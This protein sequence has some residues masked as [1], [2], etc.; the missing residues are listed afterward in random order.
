MLG[1]LV[2]LQLSGP[3]PADPPLVTR[4]RS[5][6]PITGSP[7][8][9]TRKEACWRHSICAHCLTCV[10]ASSVIDKFVNVSIPV[11]QVVIGLLAALVLSVRRFTW[12]PSSLCCSSLPLPVSRESQHSCASSQPEQYFVAG[13]CPGSCQRAFPGRLRPPHMDPQFL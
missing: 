8:F 4:T 13:D 3:P 7:S 6:T 12:N 2:D 1:T 10:A 9:L 5:S 11:I